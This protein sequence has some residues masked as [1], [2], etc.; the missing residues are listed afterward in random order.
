M[1]YD[2]DK[3]VHILLL[4]D[5][6]FHKGVNLTIGERKHLEDEWVAAMPRRRHIVAEQSAVGSKP[7]AVPLLFYAP[8]HCDFIA[9]L[10]AALLVFGFNLTKL[11]SFEYIDKTTRKTEIEA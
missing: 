10:F 3:S 6:I 7:S 4:V 9:A 8:V 1:V 2:C 11:M 5:N